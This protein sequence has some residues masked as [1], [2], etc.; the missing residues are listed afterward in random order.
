[1]SIVPKTTSPLKRTMSSRDMNFQIL[2]QTKKAKIELVDDT[3]VRNNRRPMEWEL[4]QSKKNGMHYY[5]YDK[6]FIC[7]ENVWKKNPPQKNLQCIA[8]IMIKIQYRIQAIEEMSEAILQENPNLE[9]RTENLSACPKTW[10]LGV[11]H[12]ILNP[13]RTFVSAAKLFIAW[14][15]DWKSWSLEEREIRLTLVKREQEMILSYFNSVYDAI[16]SEI[17][18]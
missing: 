16:L 12:S 2:Q 5:V 1:M 15:D 9:D 3:F 6:E 17:K 10:A 8:S 7:F 13:N 11:S 14:Q 18:D 4:K